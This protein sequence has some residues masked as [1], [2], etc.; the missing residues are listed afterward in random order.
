MGELEKESE[1][2]GGREGRGGETNVGNEGQ[3]PKVTFYTQLMTP[4]PF[5]FPDV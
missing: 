5:P 4:F 3:I 2:E 1:R